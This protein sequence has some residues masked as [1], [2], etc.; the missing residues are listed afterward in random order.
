M[1]ELTRVQRQMLNELKPMPEQRARLD[2]AMEF[3]P[4]EYARLTLGHMSRDMDDKWDALLEDDWLYWHRSWTGNCVYQTRIERR[5]DR[6]VT[7]ET[8]VNRD[9]QQ[10]N[11][12]DDRYDAALLAFLIDNFL[13]GKR[14]PFPTPS[15]LPPDLPPGIFQHNVANLSYAETVWNRGKPTNDRI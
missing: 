10:Y 6:F 5:D 3:S 15:D 13:L 8:W 1:S 9:P 2:G 11:F 14:T 4:D 7:A 12:T